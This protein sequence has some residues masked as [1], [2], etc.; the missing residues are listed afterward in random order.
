MPPYFNAIINAYIFISLACPYSIPP[1]NVSDPI[2]SNISSFKFHTNELE[3]VGFLAVFNLLF[4]FKKMKFG[5]VVWAI[6][7]TILVAEAFALA[8]YGTDDP[9]KMKEERR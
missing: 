2:R 9:N 3:F 4:H 5:A 1:Y 7:K 8:T 6:V